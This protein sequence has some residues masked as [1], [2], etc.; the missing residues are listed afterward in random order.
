MRGVRLRG[1]PHI[2]WIDGVKRALDPRGIS[3]E[4]G[5]VVVRDRN[6]W[7]AVVNA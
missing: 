1:R 3:V 4:Q 5:R 7:K 6:E 2:G